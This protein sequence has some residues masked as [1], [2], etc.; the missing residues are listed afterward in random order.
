MT[1]VSSKFT[2][3]GR[4]VLVGSRSITTILFDG[5]DVWQALGRTDAHI[6]TL[7][8]RLG[9]EYRTAFAY[10]EGGKLVRIDYA[11]FLHEADHYPSEETTIH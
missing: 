8:E 10:H 4:Y 11:Y 9:C 7:A 6:A 1:L 5:E 2:R 3:H